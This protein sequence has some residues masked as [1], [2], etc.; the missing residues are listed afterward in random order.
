MKKTILASILALFAVGTAAC[1][2]TGEPA[3]PALAVQKLRSQI[4][5]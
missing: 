4:N 2:N 3:I 5:H 1:G